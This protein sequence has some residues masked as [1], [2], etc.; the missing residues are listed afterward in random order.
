MR[1]SMRLPRPRYV[2]LVLSTVG[3]LVSPV[4]PAAVADNPPAPD[5]TGAEAQSLKDGCQR[6]PAALIA[7]Q[8]PEWAYVYNTPQ[9]QPPPPPRWVSGVLD[10]YDHRFAPVHTSGGDFAFGHDTYDFNYN[11]IP[12]PEYTFLLAGHG[13]AGASNA[14]GSYA[15]R[16]EGTARLHTEW[17]DLT[18]PKFAWAE[19]GDRVTMLGSWVWDCGHWGTPTNVFSPDYGLPR[20]GQPCP[21]LPGAPV[22]TDP[23]QCKITGEDTEFHPYRAVFV[24]RQQ[25]PDSYFYPYPDPSENGVNP[26]KAL[27][28]NPNSLLGEN[29]G[30]IFVSTD[31]T[32]AGKLE[33]CAHKF[34]PPPSVVL[35]NPAFYPATFKACVE[36]EPNWQ[37]V[38]GHYSFFLPAPPRPTRDA[39]LVF[40]AVKRAS[41]NAPAPRLKAEG[42]GVRVKFDL[43]STPNRRLV[44]GYTIFAGWS[45]VPVSALPDHLRVTLDRLVIHRAMDPGCSGGAPI[46][47][48]KAEST[49]QNQATTAPGDWNLYWDV[50]GIWGRWLDRMHRPE[51][52]LLVRDGQVLH[53]ESADLYVPPGKGWRLFV[54]GRE[55]DINVADP[56]RPMRDCP[57]NRELADGNDVIGSGVFTFASAASSLGAH[58]LNGPT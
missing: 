13:P 43:H 56:T 17:E 46:P 27:G 53:T 20:V 52:E 51:G 55:C 18:V 32:R 39:R 23:S 48:C 22:I 21:L 54:H 44:M 40:R 6:D 5:P 26:Y 35:P 58:W 19:P 24:E 4:T 31:K 50:N 33:D 3:V 12:D 9:D 36:T 42:N 11:L 34:P 29:E 14:T 47:G 10:S 8:T 45:L 41:V 28:D 7:Q 1:L 2:V 49:R 38:S 16:G 25:Q 15:G 37:D 57:S 30:D